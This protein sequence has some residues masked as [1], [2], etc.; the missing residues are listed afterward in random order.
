MNSIFSLA[1][2]LPLF[3]YSQKIDYRDYHLNINKAEELFFMQQKVDSCLYYYDNVFSTYDF[4]FVK[5]LVNAAQI[6]LFSKKPYKKYIEQAFTQ[7]LKLETIEKYALFKKVIPTLKKD[8]RLI[9]KYKIARSNYIKKIDFE[10]LDWLYKNAIQDQKDKRLKWFKYMNLVYKTSNRMMDLTQKKGFPGDKIIGLGDSLI[11]KEI[12]KPWLDL[13]QQRK[14]DSR[15]F[16]MNTNDKGLSATE[17]SLVIMVHNPCSYF[18]YKNILIKEMIKGNIHPRDIGLIYDNTYR[19]RG[20]FPYYC[21]VKLKG[22]YRLNLFTDYSTHNDIEE[23]NA[24][25]KKLY[26][27]ST[28]VDDQKKEYEIE[29]GFKLFSGFWNCR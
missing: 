16:Y 27:V 3:A 5:D 20:Y 24:M 1:L 25:R 22:V 13:Y 26:I 11:F 9:K 6:A 14:H 2:L 29:Y 28:H 7:G 19:F 8:K 10:Y 12:N 4:I 21:N 18:L 23:T 15:L 17:Y